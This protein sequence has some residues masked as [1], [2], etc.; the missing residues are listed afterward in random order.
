M[1]RPTTSP[2]RS[3]PASARDA[4][5]TGTLR[6]RDSSRGKLDSSRRML[7]STRV[8]A[9]PPNGLDNVLTNIC[10]HMTT[11]HG[12][13]QETIGAAFVSSPRTAMLG[14]C[15]PATDPSVKAAG[16]ALRSDSAP[17]QLRP[18]IANC[19]TQ[20][21]IRNNKTAGFWR[22][23]RLLRCE[24][25]VEAAGVEPNRARPANWLMAWRFWS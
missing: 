21:Q 8:R 23:Q 6:S 13:S 14:R 16:V 11:K 25:M 12:H 19:P 2:S 4:A 10:G 5:D 9:C 15:R 20:A 24:R 3:R 22:I 17:A 1:S 18:K 7:T